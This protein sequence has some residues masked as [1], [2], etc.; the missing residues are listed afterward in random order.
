VIILNIGLALVV[1]ARLVLLASFVLSVSALEGR[2]VSISDRLRI[3]QILWV[4][5]LERGLFL[6]YPSRC[7]NN[8][9]NI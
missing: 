7:P 5:F 9:R 3:I 4:I 1:V 2:E 8:R 6:P